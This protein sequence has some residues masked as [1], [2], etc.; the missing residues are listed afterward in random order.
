MPNLC[1]CDNLPMCILHLGENGLEKYSLAKKW[2]QFKIVLLFMDHPVYRCVGTGLVEVSLNRIVGS[3]H[4]PDHILMWH[5][6]LSLEFP[7]FGTW[8]ALVVVVERVAFCL[9]VVSRCLASGV[10]GVVTG[11]IGH[12]VSAPGAASP[13]PLSAPVHRLCKLVQQSP[14]ACFCVFVFVAV[15]PVHQSRYIRVRVS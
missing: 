12:T 5:F 15:F 14:S 2:E 13:D 9:C 11:Q 7:S 8:F 6:V 10:P 3:M 4:L 1:C